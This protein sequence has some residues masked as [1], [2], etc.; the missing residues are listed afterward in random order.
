MI[1]I[2]YKVSSAHHLSYQ[3]TCFTFE[4][5]YCEAGK[6]SKSMEAMTLLFH[7]LFCAFST[8][9]MGYLKDCNFSLFPIYSS[10]NLSTVSNAETNT[11]RKL[12]IY[13]LLM[14]MHDAETS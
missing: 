13:S 9:T 4:F 10:L 1:N 2:C 12:I 8:Y 11:A 14:I 7:T 3:E 6:P 5:S